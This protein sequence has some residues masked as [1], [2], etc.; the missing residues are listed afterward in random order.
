MLNPLRDWHDTA[1][2][3]CRSSPGEIGAAGE[4]GIHRL[5]TSVEGIRGGLRPGAVPSP[6]TLDS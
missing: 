2:T 3:R 1:E 4:K 5:G 6:P